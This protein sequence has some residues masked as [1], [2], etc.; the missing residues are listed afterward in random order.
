MALIDA[1]IAELKHESTSTRK[2]LERVPIEKGEWQPHEKSF[3]IGRLATHIAEIPAWI[4]NI[5]LV[6]EYDIATR[7]LNRHVAST[8]EELLKIFQDNIDKAVSVLG[9]I[10]EEDLSKIWSFK[11]GEKSLYE[12]PKK[13]AV[14][15]FAYNHLYHHRGQLSVYLRLMNVAVPGMYGPSADEAII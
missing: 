15:A 13:V 3:A 5:V 11:M 12:L 4:P 2:I 6:D 10:K 1:L 7:G 8:K 9:Q 14:R